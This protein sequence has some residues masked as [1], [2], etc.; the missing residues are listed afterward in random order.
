MVK[1]RY[2]CILWTHQSQ[3]FENDLLHLYG[4]SGVILSFKLN[5]RN[6]I[7]KTKLMLHHRL[8]FVGNCH[9]KH[10]W[11][12][13]KLVCVLWKK[14]PSCR[15]HSRVCIYNQTRAQERAKHWVHLKVMHYWLHFLRRSVIDCATHPAQPGSK[16]TQHEHMTWV[17]HSL[18][19]ML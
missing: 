8:C 17:T 5:H 3:S 2:F 11:L 4:W 14:G 18:L 6:K 7:R 9:D 15:I 16:A 13:F 12:F 10:F 1:V 19:V